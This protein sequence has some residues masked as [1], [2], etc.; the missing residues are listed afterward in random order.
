M[1]PNQTTFSGDSFKLGY[2][3]QSY[4]DFHM[5]TAFFFGELGA[6][7]FLVSL[8]FGFVPGMVLGLLC[9]GVGKPYYHMSH[10][11]VPMRSWRAILRPDRSWISRGLI[12]IAVFVPCGVLVVLDALYGWS[13]GGMLGKLVQIVAVAA[14]LLVMSY[15]G[16][17]M[18]HS[19]AIALWNSGLMPISSVVYSLASGAAVTLALG[20]FFNGIDPLLLSKVVIALVAATLMVLLSLL[21]AAYHGTVGARQSL[22]LLIKDRFAKPFILLVLGAGIVLPILALW[23][24]G[25]SI[26]SGL[27]A[28][29]GVVV[30]FFTFRLLIFRAGV[31]EPQISFAARLGLS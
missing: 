15:Q 1:P 31:F 11:G 8:Y 18:S 19:T 2:R 6:G 14:C 21:H 29:V 30:G 24:G 3:F 27:L 13:G 25:T 5:A 10:M 28:A 4:W 26:V 22:E 23:F 17:A 16:F 12:G 9:T 7:L 20:L